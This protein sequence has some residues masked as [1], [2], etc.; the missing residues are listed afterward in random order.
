MRSRITVCC[1]H[2]ELY[3]NH[4]AVERYGCPDPGLGPDEFGQI[5]RLKG[6]QEADLRNRHL[7]DYYAEALGVQLIDRRPWF[8]LDSFDAAEIR[9]FRLEEIGRPRVAVAIGE[10]AFHDGIERT[11]WTELLK[12]LVFA[13][14]AKILQI[15]PES[16]P[17]LEG[18]VNLLGRLT[19]R[20]AAAILMDCEVLICGDNGYLDLAAGV[21]TPVIALLDRDRIAFRMDAAWG[22]AFETIREDAEDQMDG[23]MNRVIRTAAL[24]CRRDRQLSR[25]IEPA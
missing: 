19:C 4:P 18:G 5:F 10:D 13:Q 3:R 14:D 7:V 12:R 20:Q 25:G 1:E 6:R 24:Y 15:G 2:A 17:V 21:Q 23:Y 11:I 22:T 16:R 9:R 8:C